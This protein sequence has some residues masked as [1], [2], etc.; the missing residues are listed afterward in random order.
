MRNILLIAKREYLEQIRGR[1][2][3]FSTVALP[4]LVAALLA[5]S[6]YMD[7]K[8]G[9]GKRIAI[10]ADG[11]GGEGNGDKASRL[12]AETALSV[13]KEAKP[14]TP[15]PA[16]MR[17]IFDA[18]AARVFQAAQHEGRMATT[19]LT[20]VFRHDKVTLAH[21]GDSRAYL[22]RGGKIKRLTTDHSYTALQVK[23]GLLLAGTVIA[24]EPSRKT[25]RIEMSKSSLDK[26]RMPRT[27]VMPWVFMPKGSTPMMAT[28]AMPMMAR[29]MAISII[30]KADSQLPVRSPQSPVRRRWTLDS[31]ARRP[32]SA[33]QCE[34][35]S[36]AKT[37]GLSTLDWFDIFIASSRYCLCWHAHLNQKRD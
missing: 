37:A 22:I 31:L 20:S 15:G 35:G 28:S 16:L 9:T 13:F 7:H 8:A 4:L 34:D 6:Y 26:N 2:F 21:V 27:Y 23:L 3:K 17:Q 30:V 32:V 5:F 18:S 12:A 25:L 1:A 11:D 24:Y 19:L 10:V 14:E 29:Q 33:K 36:A